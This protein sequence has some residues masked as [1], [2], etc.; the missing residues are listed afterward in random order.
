MTTRQQ[1]VA[2]LVGVTTVSIAGCGL[3]TGPI[4]AEAS[5]ARTSETARSETGYTHQRTRDRT[6]EQ[7]AAAGD[8][9]RD[10]SLTNWLSEY[11]R[12]PSGAPD[13]AA[14]FLL[15][16]TPTITVGGQSANPF[17]RFGEKRLIREV[18]RRSSRNSPDNE[19]REMGTRSVSVLEN[20]AE[21]TQ[22][23][24]TQMIGGQSVDI[25]IHV[26]S[27][28][29]DGDALVIIGSHPAPSQFGFADEAENIDT[30]VRGIEHPTDP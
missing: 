30:L 19:L 1:L 25:R 10:I 26:G 18:S 12:A 17:E 24:T 6:F 9:Q 2:A 11:T 8:Q 4:E 23:E 14:G 7:T 13:A 5:P 22:Y 28:T 3:L 15:L 16:A 21:L 29:N 27:L 20:S